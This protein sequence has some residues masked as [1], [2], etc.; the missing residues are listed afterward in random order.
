MSVAAAFV[1]LD[2]SRT[3]IQLAVRPTGE[4]WNTRVD[5]GGILEA[6]D[7]LKDIDP[8]LVVMEAQGGPELPLAGMLATLGLRFVLVSPRY[9][10]DFA[11]VVGRSRIDR[12]QAGLLAHFAELV[13]PE[14]RTPTTETIQQLKALRA[15]REHVSRMLAD[16]RLRLNEGHTPPLV[17]KDMKVHVHF[18]ERSILLID[19]EFSRTVRASQLWI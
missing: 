10:R 6:A 11:R 13:R 5:D 18:L 16:E 14:V 4:Q 9:I 2:V 12:D 3:S 17:H 7:H 15:R 19:E 1:G 8:Q